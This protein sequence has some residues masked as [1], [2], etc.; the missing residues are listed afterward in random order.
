MGIGFE[1][2]T[3]P[4]KQ[5]ELKAGINKLCRLTA[6]Q[7]RRVKESHGDKRLTI[8]SAKHSFKHTGNTLDRGYQ[9]GIG[10]HWLHTSWEVSTN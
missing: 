3:M 8:R 4:F 5:C 7:P 1:T 9:I 10:Q 2:G 6:E